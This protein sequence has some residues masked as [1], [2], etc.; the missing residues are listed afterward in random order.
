MSRSDYLFNEGYLSA[1]FEG[2]R[3]ELDQAAQQVP[4]AHALASSVDELAGEL[5]DRYRIEPLDLDWDQMSVSVD[6]TRVDVSH[7]PMR[8]VFDRGGPFFIPG[9]TVTYHVPFRGERDLFKFQPSTFTL[10]PPRAQVARDEL[11]IAETRPADATGGLRE[12][13]D[14]TAA[15][16]KSYVATVRSD[17]ER[18]NAELEQSARGAA[19]RRRAKVLADRELVASFGLPVKRRDDAAPTYATPAIRRAVSPERKSGRAP[20][21]AEPVLPAEEY[22]HI[23][24]V[25]QKMT[26]V[27]E[28]SPKAFATM[29][30]ESLRQHFLVQL[31][32]QYEG[33]ATGETFNYEGKTDILVRDRDRNLFIG[34]CKFWKGA[35]HL[36]ETIDQILGYASWRDTKTAILIFNR[37][38]DLTKVLAQISPAVRSHP[39]FVREIT[40]GGETD[41]RFVLHHRDDNERELT[42]TV[43]VFDIPA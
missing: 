28:R 31:N 11:Q 17:V 42:L 18:F 43:L 27:L 13:L 12:E 26:H 37:N 24:D 32:G 22:E 16:I 10:N 5:I 14:R 6:D 38:R 41:F 33:N 3:R 40:Y 25:L 19:E 36:C 39:S 9:T 4:P 1:A 29:D 21:P 34:E 2:K 23:L 20:G 7:D 15:S 30:E 35:Q 8:M